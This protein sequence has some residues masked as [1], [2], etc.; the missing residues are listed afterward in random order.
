MRFLMTINGLILTAFL[1]G[2]ATPSVTTSVWEHYDACLAAATT[3]FAAVVECGKQKRTAHCL[4]IGGC[5]STGNAFVE[6]ADSLATWVQKKQ[7]S[8]AEARRRLVGSFDVCR[9]DKGS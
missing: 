7:I 1:S 3:P 9:P 2:C 5:S 4:A 8:E 6:Y